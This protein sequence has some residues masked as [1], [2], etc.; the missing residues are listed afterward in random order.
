MG[1]ARE[2]AAPRGFEQ[3]LDAVLRSVT[4]ALWTLAMST[5]PWVSMSR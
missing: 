2:E 1:E 5:N 3:E 4:L